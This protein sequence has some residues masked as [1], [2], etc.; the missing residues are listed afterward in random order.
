M[1]S[2]FLAICRPL[3]CGNGG[4]PLLLPTSSVIVAPA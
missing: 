2:E 4:A 1:P 3:V